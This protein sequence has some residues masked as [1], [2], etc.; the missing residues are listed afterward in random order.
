M[1][2]LGKAAFR[3]TVKVGDC[4]YANTREFDYSGEVRFIDGESVL[5]A[6]ISGITHDVRLGDIYVWGMAD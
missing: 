1:N 2:N 6:D 5:I 4:I 3:A